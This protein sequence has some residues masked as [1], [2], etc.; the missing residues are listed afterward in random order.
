MPIEFD[1]NTSTYYQ[2][3]YTQN[4]Y[5]QA[6]VENPP[7]TPT[8]PQDPAQ[9]VSAEKQIP[10]DPALVEPQDR[11]RPSGQETSLTGSIVDTVV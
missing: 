1:P 3:S 5:A 7:P 2:T 8:G 6:P 9:A 10:Q 11:P 4:S